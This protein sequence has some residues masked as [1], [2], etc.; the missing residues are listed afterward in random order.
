MIT[1]AINVVDAVDEAIPI[2]RQHVQEIHD[3]RRLPDAVVDALRAT[4]IN[5]MVLPP[6]SADWRPQPPT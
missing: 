3:R 1:E 5:R 6:Y 2:V 4:G